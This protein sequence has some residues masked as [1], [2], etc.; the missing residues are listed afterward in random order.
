VTFVENWI[1]ERTATSRWGAIVLL[2]L[3]AQAAS[4][5]GS[6][7]SGHGP[8]TNDPGT[9]EM[10]ALLADRAAG[11]DPAQLPFLVN[12]RRADF[13][14]RRLMQPL[15]VERRVALRLTQAQE[16]LNAGR[17][18][19]SLEALDALDA[20]LKPYPALRQRLD[21]R[22]ALLRAM[23]HLRM[24]EEQ[25]CCGSNNR[26]SCLMPLKGEGIHRRREGST[27]AVEI[28]ESV[29]DEAPA[30]M[31]ARWL[32]SIAHMTLG[33]YPDAVPPRHLIPPSAF[34]SE[35][36]LPR[37]PNVAREAGLEILGHAG[38]SILDDFDA[39]GRLD[40][41]VSSMGLQDQLRFFRNAGD[42]TFEDRT[43]Q[44]GLTGEVGGLNVVQA[45]YD[46][47]GF[48]DV[49]V[50]RGAWMLSEGRFPLSLLRNDGEGGFSDVTRA[51]GLLRFAP[52][53]TATWFDYDGDGWLDLYVGN[54]SA[55]VPGAAVHPCELFHNDG[56]GTFTEV[57]RE[58][59]VDVVGY[60]KAVA[61][62]DFD[63]DGRP[64]LY[65]SVLGGDNLLLRNEGRVTRE[66]GPPAWRFTDVAREAG[67][68]APKFSFG[69]FFFDYDNDGWQDL[70]VVGYPPAGAGDVA[71]DSLA[72]PTKAER[73]RLYHN[74]QDGRFEDV[75][76]AAGL[77]RVVLGMGLNF[78]DLDNDGFL[79]FYVGT[80]NPDLSTLV[81]NRMFRNAGG[82]SFQDVT[83]AGDFGH[84]QK[85]H[86]IS[87]GD[88]DN[89]GDQDVFSQMGG[90][91]L[92]DTAWSA[93]Y[94]NP[95]F[96]AAWL[97]LEVEGVRSNRSAIGA[98]VAVVVATEAGPRT[99]HRTVGSGGSFGASPLRQ[100][101]GLGAAQRIVSVE[102]RWPASGQRQVVSGL[103][104]DHRYRIRE[105][106]EAAVRVD[107]PAFELGSAMARAEARALGAE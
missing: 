70:F 38:G 102:I 100:E 62:G 47:D 80:G 91:Y 104:L 22:L 65:V 81:P 45:D 58:S 105:G 43:T 55:R 28:L 73:G 15:P 49:L 71:A 16:L 64:D 41:V 99:V 9:R 44:A 24:A 33:S 7:A 10:A 76:R 96:P 72:L 2:W 34:E 93:L 69:T 53:Q 46:N 14:A 13:L 57:A 60:V 61:S 106:S 19:D 68:A 94:E 98:R 25:N 103:E 82:R 37:F 89:D 1:R 32:L 11:V 17:I 63:N 95:G 30:N 5:H 97:S 107:R 50:L 79:D 8:V 27:R 39:D 42:G 54:E 101:I 77:Y 86:A 23:A 21:Q 88:V 40:L 26:D 3:L 84:L 78:G 36:P 35:F 83:T 90:A 6:R 4:G 85:G 29:L 48:V 52:T 12:D 20:E 87:F 75:T 74:R 92:A 56:D 66:G 31:K 59:G 51:A 18:Q 67:V